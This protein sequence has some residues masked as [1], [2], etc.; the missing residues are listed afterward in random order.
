MLSRT[1]I[2]QKSTEQSPL[3][4][5]H[6]P[7]YLRLW[8][9]ESLTDLT[10]IRRCSKWIEIVS[11]PCRPIPVHLR[12]YYSDPLTSNCTRLWVGFLK[13]GYINIKNEYYSHR[14]LC[15]PTFNTHC[16]DLSGAAD[17]VGRL[18]RN[19]PVMQISSNFWKANRLGG[20]AGYLVVTIIPP[21]FNHKIYWF[22]QWQGTDKEYQNVKKSFKVCPYIYI[23]I[24]MCIYIYIYF[25]WTCDF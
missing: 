6:D 16:V 11:L 13:G 15:H 17:T 18:T 24:Y 25:F 7:S 2:C 1:R 19:P 14:T 10:H 9:S 21:E 5:T 3:A 8:I 23:Y 12:L 4:L 20:L 22:H